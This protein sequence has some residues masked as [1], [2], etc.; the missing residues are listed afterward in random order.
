MQYK[1]IILELI[2]QRPE[3]HEQLRQERKLLATVDQAATELKSRHNEYMEQLAER[4]PEMAASA[5]YSA[6]F[7]MA[8]KELV[9]RL[10]PASAMDDHEELSLD[11]AMAHVR[12][13]SRLA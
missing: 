7:E 8:L 4:H 12:N 6:A 9:D 3:M 2:Q 5:A 1:T 13:P 11:A 10:L